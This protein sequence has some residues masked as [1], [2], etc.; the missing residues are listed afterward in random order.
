MDSR[1][2]KGQNEEIN[3]KEV[4]GDSED[5]NSR[6]DFHGN[7][8]TQDENL[9]KEELR[10]QELLLALLENMENAAMASSDSSFASGS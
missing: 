10:N 6:E 8:Q 4:G 2:G 9:S 1:P 7:E 3:A 5:L